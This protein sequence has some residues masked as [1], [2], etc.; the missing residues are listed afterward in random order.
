MTHEQSYGTVDGVQITDDVIDRLVA[1]AEAGFPGVTPRSAGGR[2]A[3]GDGPAATVA[4]R[5]DPELH[6]ELLERMAS[7]DANA[8]QIIRAALR[9]YL[10]VA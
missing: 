3:M 9:D 6:R 5:L 1:N 7:E 10:K 4:V 8:S 2:P